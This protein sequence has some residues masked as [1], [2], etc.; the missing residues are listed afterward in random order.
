MILLARKMQ[1][2]LFL[3]AVFAF[4]HSELSVSLD[5]GKSCFERYYMNNSTPG[6]PPEKNEPL[7]SLVS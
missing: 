1:S 4:S 7:C 3:L 6:P 5:S 2:Q